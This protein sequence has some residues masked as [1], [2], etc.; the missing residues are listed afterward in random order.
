M[1]KA[2]RLEIRVCTSEFNG[3][4]RLLFIKIVIPIQRKL[5][6]LPFRIIQMILGQARI[7][8]EMD[9]ETM[10][11]KEQYQSILPLFTYM[12]AVCVTL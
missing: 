4:C 5:Q 1:A 6:H 12:G 2:A 8:I 9:Y 3:N 7:T 11:E 10:P